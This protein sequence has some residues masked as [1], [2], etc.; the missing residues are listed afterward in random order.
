MRT[1]FIVFFV[2][3]WVT[4]TAQ[5]SLFTAS[6]KPAAAEV[7]NALTVGLVFKSKVE[8]LITH[9]RVYKSSATDEGTYVLGIYTDKGEPL[10]TQNYRATGAVGWRRV[11]LDQA[12]RIEPNVNYLATA[13]LPV[14]KYGSRQYMFTADRVRGNLTAPASSKVAGN[15]RYRYGSEMGFPQSTYRS[16]AYYVDV[17]FSPRKPLIVNAGRDTSYAM[18]RDTIRLKGLVTGDGT[19]FSWNM[20]D[21]LTLPYFDSTTVVMEASNTLEPYLTGFQEGLYT[22]ELL[23]WDMYG[24]QSRSLVQ[25]QVTADPKGVIFE[26]LRDGT[27]RVV[28]DKKYFLLKTN[29]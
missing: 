12:V 10:F 5:D 16:S 21:S 6:D 1:F 13:W 8:G 2:L 27:W 14:G 28:D 19:W 17:V 9:I 11:K 25:I 22:F 20:V 23:G 7:D 29:Q 26:L 18:P 4:T 24:S 3:S 15:Y